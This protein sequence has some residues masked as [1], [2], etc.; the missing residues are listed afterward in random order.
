MMPLSATRT[1]VVPRGRFVVLET[2]GNERVGAV[3]LS[4]SSLLV[5]AVDGDDDADDGKYF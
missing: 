4:V 1:G 3:G 5:L 2:F